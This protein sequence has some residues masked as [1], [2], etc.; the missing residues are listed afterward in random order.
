MKVVENLEEYFLGTFFFGEELNIV[1]NQYIKVLV[2]IDE[3]VVIALLGRIDEL[4]DEFLGAHKNHNFLLVCLL[5]EVTNGMGQMGLA[6]SASTK[7]HKGV[8]RGSARLLSDGQTCI[9]SQ[10]VA[11]TF[12]EII[13][14]VTGIQL[15]VDIHALQTRNDERILDRRIQVDRHTQFVLY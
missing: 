13:E 11:I 10:F 4:V 3:L 15:T 6:Q 5:D 9:S 14:R 8:K 1:Y 12:H 2:E 7:N